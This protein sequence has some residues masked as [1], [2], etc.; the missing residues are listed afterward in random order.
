MPE[1][2]SHLFQLA[3]YVGAWFVIS[4]LLLY[5]AGSKRALPV[6]IVIA[7]VSIATGLWHFY[8]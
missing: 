5:F 3:L 7:M 1:N 4:F 6:A 8:R 2:N